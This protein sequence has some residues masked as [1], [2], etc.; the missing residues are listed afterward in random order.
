MCG[1]TRRGTY[2]SVRDVVKRKG[3]IVFTFSV[4]LTKYLKKDNE[5]EMLV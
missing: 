5:R 4:A 2:V 1:V 3:D